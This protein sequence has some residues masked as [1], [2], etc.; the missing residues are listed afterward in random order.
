M[1]KTKS[2]QRKKSKKDGIRICI[3]RRIK[4]SY[5][6][7]F[8]TPKIS[9]SERLLKDYIINKKISWSQFKPKFLKQLNRNKK[10]LQFNSSLCQDSDITLLCWEKSPQKCHRRLVVEECQKINPKLKVVIK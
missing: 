6:F 5:D 2:L 7:D 9:P 1:L 4:P 3:M 10:Y 8:W